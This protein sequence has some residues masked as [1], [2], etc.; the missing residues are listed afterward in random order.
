MLR[1]KAPDS[2]YTDRIRS[3]LGLNVRQALRSCC[4]L[5]C[6]FYLPIHLFVFVFTFRVSLLIFEDPTSILI[7]EA[8]KCLGVEHLT[9]TEEKR[10]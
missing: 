4:A 5:S 9:V 6:V 10:Q 3:P 1:Q 7:T 8:D 2:Q